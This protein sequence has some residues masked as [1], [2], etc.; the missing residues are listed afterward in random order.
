MG[1]TST[2]YP[3]NQSAIVTE[4]MVLICLSYLQVC[5][6][7]HLSSICSP[8]Q[9]SAPPVPPEHIQLTTATLAPPSATFFPFHACRF[10]L[11]L[12]HTHTFCLP[13]SLHSLDIFAVCCCPTCRTC[14]ADVCALVESPSNTSCSASLSHTIFSPSS[15][16]SSYF[17][18]SSL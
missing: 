11:S 8:I 15:L 6:S 13:L 12:T 4:L 7:I 16:S 14:D 18:S 17:L 3:V 2:L 9:P 1:G 5:P 10:T